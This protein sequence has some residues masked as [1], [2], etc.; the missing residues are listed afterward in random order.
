[1]EKSP[2][3]T[4]ITFFHFT[5]ANKWWIFRQM[6]SYNFGPDE[7]SGLSFVRLMGSGSG[8]GFSAWPDFSTYALLSVWKSEAH[9][10]DF[11]SKNLLFQDFSAHANDYS[12]VFMGNI[13]AQGLWAGGMPFDDFQEYQSGPIGVITRATIYPS[14]LIDFWLNVPATG[15]IVNQQKGLIYAKG[16]GEYPLFMQ[17]T[18]SFW[19]S[20]EAMMQYAYSSSA[21]SDVIQKTRERNWYKEELFSNFLPYRIEGTMSHPLRKWLDN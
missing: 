7:V 17:A 12:T 8:G 5:G 20:K 13:K 11:F 10:E 6:G 21:H 14:K 15:K 18:I 1:M 16:I 9:A 3:I 2:Q 19:E 4:C